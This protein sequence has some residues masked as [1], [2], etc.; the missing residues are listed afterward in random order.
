VV[1]QP[2]L[3]PVAYAALAEHLEANGLTTVVLRLPTSPDDLS[4]TVLPAALQAA[5]DRP[6][7]LVGHGYGGRAALLSPLP[8]DAIC[9]IALL[10]VPLV[11]RST[12]WPRP[13][14]DP[15]DHPGG[16][17]LRA[18]R[19]SQT[20]PT[21]WPLTREESGLEDAWLGRISTG[22]LDE[23]AGATSH[24]VSVPDGLPTWVAVAPLDELAPPETIRNLPTSTVFS[25]W[26]MLRG[27]GYDASTGDLLTHPRP[28]SHLARWAR[29][30][31]D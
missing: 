28:A 25:R 27:W 21:I 14:P 5:G 1:P 20:A 6:V 10:G 15:V 9:A 24:P 30:A 2:G 7:V 22:W 23:L 11:V 19:R 4:R 26:G 31:C 12:S 18:A 17:S 13:L 8:S 16:I 3:R 29:S